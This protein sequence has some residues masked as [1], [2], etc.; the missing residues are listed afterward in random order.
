VGFNCTAAQLDRAMREAAPNGL[1]YINEANPY[2]DNW[3]DHFWGPEVYPKLKKLKREWD[4]EG[5]L[6]A[7]STPGTEAWDVIEYGERLC[8]KL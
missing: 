3:Q 6:Y 4:P 1:A 7:V 5:V 2:M 8:K